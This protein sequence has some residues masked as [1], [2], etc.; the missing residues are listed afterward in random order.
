MTQPIRTTCPYCGVGCGVLATRGLDGAVQVQGDPDHPANFGRLCSKGA[1]LGETVGLDGRLLYPLV[2]GKRVNW[3]TA[4]GTV[5]DGF[6][7]IIDEHG[8]NA[9]GFYVSGQLL[10]E[11]Y[12]VVNKLAKGFIGTANI[13]TNSRL[14]MSSAV[15]GHK[16][17]FGADTVPGCYA[18]LEQA[19]LLVLAGS[20]MAWCHP[21]LYQRIKRAK[22][23]R[24][25]MKVVVIDPRRTDSC[26]IADLH[27]PLAPG[28]DVALWNGVLAHLADAGMANLAFL[29]RNAQGYA[30]TLEAARQD[31]ADAGRITGLEPELLARFYALYA[32]T[33]RVVTVF[34]Q[35]VNQSSAGTDKVNAITNCHL[36]TGRIGR[37]GMG[38]FSITGQ[39]NAMGGREVGGLAN[40]LAAHMEFK[41][42][43]LD[44]V[45]RFWRAP[46]LAEQPGLPAVELFRAAAEG[47][48]KA[49]WI[50]A[51]N[52]MV[53]IPDADLVRQALSRCELVVVSDCMQRTD[54]ANLAH[55]LL[56]ALT[57]GEKDGMVTNSERRISRQRL[58]LA[59]PGEAKPDWWAL[60]EVAKRLGFAVD[61]EYPGPEAIFA[62][63]ARLS[64]FENDGSRDFDIGALA[65]LSARR[66]EELE[67]VQWPLREGADAGIARLFGQGGFLHPDGKARLIPLRH[68][69][70][71]NPVAPEFPLALNTGRIRDQ[72][73]TMART[74]K[75]PRL[76]AHL[77]E[78][79]AQL[80]PEDAAALRVRDDDVVELE[81]RW[82]RVRVRARLD[83]GQRRGAVFVPM[84]WNDQYAGLAR[85]D[86]VVNPAVD[87][88]SGEPEFKHTPVR[89]KPLQLDWHGF[90][91]TRDALRV[92]LPVAYWARARGNQHWRYELGGT[93]APDWWAWLRREI[94]PRGEW[95]RY[96]DPARGAYRAACLRDGRVEACLFIAGKPDLLP[97]RVWLANL[98]EKEELSAAERLGLLSGR[99]PNGTDVGRIVCACFGV[100]EKTIRAA[101]LEGASDPQE[102][103]Y[104]CKAGG[105]CGS[106][107][108]E[109][110]R[111]IADLNRQSA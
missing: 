39:P 70:P 50:M 96:R 52:P 6:A 11:D 94:G 86:A 84:H 16:R 82:G 57:W 60:C 110:K 40:Q 103:T 35:G 13:D 48:V 41:P 99:P 111:M 5:A 104:C 58:F 3:E 46:N 25:E 71:A 36:F 73:H 23:S 106:C 45:R 20:N 109:I 21:V 63:H 47:R 108:P 66:Y 65:G 56:P 77:P 97:D 78:P 90:L 19:D 69:G 15:A 55:V 62:E 80:H 105:N 24:P 67:P 83:D 17:A 100:G 26:E 14:C 42:Q 88:I 22:E 18:D 91:L 8:P 81:S 49:L 68:R 34:S 64:A 7:R 59:P 53:S 74:G 32:S 101:I 61:F 30:E 85:I 27:L 72:W 95:V 75:S 29:E 38:P 92:A 98:F 37:P 79:I 44:R 43:D 107:V 2:H 89:L 4:L 54:T 10:T 33:E 102:V 1:A 28:S 87:P 9:V 93:T 31:A 51:T 12:Y 76:S